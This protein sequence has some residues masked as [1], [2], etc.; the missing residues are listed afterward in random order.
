M[1]SINNLTSH[2]VFGLIL[3]LFLAT[4][5]TSN[6]GAY[7]L[8]DYSW[9]TASTT[10]YVDIPGGDGLW[11]DAFEAAMYQWS[12]NTMFE[13]YIFRDTYSNPCREDDERNGVAFA[14]SDCGDA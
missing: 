3:L 6:A 13:Y 5:I 2:K 1:K 9:P 4:R 11:N 14:A 12:V 10:F 8:A 7:E